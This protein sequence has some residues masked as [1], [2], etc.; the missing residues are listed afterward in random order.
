MSV[1]IVY[2]V[3]SWVLCERVIEIDAQKSGSNEAWLTKAFL[4]P[5]CMLVLFK[6]CARRAKRWVIAEVLNE[7]VAQQIFFRMTLN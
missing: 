6:D 7:R 3:W 4:I 2:L 1:H 5:M